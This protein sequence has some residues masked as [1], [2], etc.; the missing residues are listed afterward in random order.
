MHHIKISCEK[1]L[2]SVYIGSLKVYK[3]SYK[4][5]SNSLKLNITK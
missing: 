1:I 4:I 3:P 5:Q 2:M